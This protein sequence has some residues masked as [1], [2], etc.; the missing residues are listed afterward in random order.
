[1]NETYGRRFYEEMYAEGRIWAGPQGLLGF[2]YRLLKRF[3]LHRVLATIFLLKKSN[4]I[5]DL[6]CGDG[7]LI[8]LAKRKNL[9]DAYY[10][11][12]LAQVVV[13]RAIRN[14]KER[15][16]DTKSVHIKQAS[17]DIKLPYRNGYFDAV[18][19]I[20]V[21]EHVFDPQFS[22]KE[23]NRILSK[24]GIF[25]LEV[26][27]LVWLPRRLNVLLGKLPI[28]GEEEGWDGGHLHYFTGKAVHKLLTKNG[29]VI[30]YS[31]CT[32]IFSKVRNIWPAL[33]GG[34]IIVKAEKTKNAK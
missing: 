19:C 29:F 12:D 18:T 34:N 6:G 8:S 33:L 25:I 2:L 4:K 32:G 16:G 7:G 30:K 20:S 10:G 11:I 31:G 24:G 22:I 27:N 17:M 3:E 5:L 23:I 26:P 15:T 21:L 28:T 1:M 13:A 14:I 9:F